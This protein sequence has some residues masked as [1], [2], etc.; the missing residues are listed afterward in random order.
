M[1]MS[2][3]YADENVDYGVVVVLRQVGHDVLTVQEAGRRGGTTAYF[4]LGGASTTAFI[5][6]RPFWKSPPIILSMSMNR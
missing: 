6:A 3:L 2:L 4:C 5:F 1:P